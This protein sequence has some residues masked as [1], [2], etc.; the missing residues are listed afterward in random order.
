MKSYNKA[1][2]IV[3]YRLKIQIA[4]QY[5]TPILHQL[6]VPKCLETWQFIILTAFSTRVNVLLPTKNKLL[7]H[8]LADFYI[9]G[10]AG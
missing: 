10:N 7:P 9:K 4:Y 2:K 5:C 1:Q 6:S 3:N 8:L